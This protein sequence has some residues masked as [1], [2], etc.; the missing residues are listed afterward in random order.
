MILFRRIFLYTL[1]ISPLLS[2]TGGNE[3]STGLNLAAILNLPSLNSLNYLLQTVFFFLF[4]ILNTSRGKLNIIFTLCFLGFF[5]FFFPRHPTVFSFIGLISIFTCFLVFME[6]RS[7]LTH[8]SAKGTKQLFIAYSIYIIISVIAHF[9]IAASGEYFAND[10]M[11]GIFKNPNQMGFFLVAYYLI[12]ILK[13]RKPYGSKWDYL[14]PIIIFLLLV[15]T[16]S[17]SA[18]VAMFIIHIAHFILIKKWSYL[19]TI[20][21]LLVPLAAITS[22]HLNKQEIIEIVSR[23]PIS[24]LDDVGNMRFKIF[25]D[26]INESST[27]QILFGKDVSIGTNGMIYEQ[28]KR[29]KDIKWLDNLVNVLFYNWGITG[30]LFLCVILLIDVGKNFPVVKPRI[31]ITLFFMIAA[32]FFL[33]SDFFPLA[34][35]LVYLKNEFSNDRQ[36]KIFS[37][38]TVLQ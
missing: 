26:I 2:L 20:T 17:R 23:R 16:G 27:K 28:K 5:I 38:N 7:G 1:L 25:N 3:F 35:T 32:F 19:I 10:R 13:I 22:Y 34:L 36:N 24:T 6:D 4:I 31:L 33:L 14:L 30:L 37:N 15:L 12:Y 8:I 29:N 11:M 18:I 9:I 21:L